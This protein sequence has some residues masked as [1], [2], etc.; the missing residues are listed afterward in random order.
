MELVQNVELKK[1][2]LYYEKNNSDK[3]DPQRLCISFEQKQLSSKD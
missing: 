3:H 1:T 2:V